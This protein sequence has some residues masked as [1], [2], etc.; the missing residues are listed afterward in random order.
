M[1]HRKNS[2]LRSIAQIQSTVRH[3]I[4]GFKASKRKVLV[5]GLVSVV[6]STI[7]LYSHTDTPV[8][9]S[10]CILMNFTGKKVDVAPFTDAYETIK[11][12]PIFQASTAYDNTD[13][14]ETTILILN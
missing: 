11:A 5:K 12:V 3:N 10:N 6:Y 14:G 8:C 7:D 13:T 1:H 9:R 2:G 4:Y